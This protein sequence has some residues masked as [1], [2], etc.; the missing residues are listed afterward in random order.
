[1]LEGLVPTERCLACEVCCRFAEAGSLMA[2]VF[3]PAEMS[4]AEGAGLGREAF[5]RTGCGRSEPVILKRGVG[6]WIC[7]AFDQGRNRCRFY[8]NRPLDCRLYPFVLTYDEAGKSVQ[9]AADLACPFVVDNLCTPEFREQAQ[10]LARSIDAAMPADLER[11]AA[12]LAFRRPEFEVLAPLP[13]LSRQ[14]CRSDLGLARLTPQAILD[15]QPFFV[16]EPCE[17]AH[18]SLGPIFVW[19]DLFNLYYRVV[20]DRVLVFGE[21]GGAAFLWLPPAGVGEM[22]PAVEEAVSIL[23]R[24]GRAADTWRI[25]N[26]AADQLA[27]F[28]R[29]GLRAAEKSEEF[30]YHRASLAGLTGRRFHGMRAASNRFVKDHRQ[31]TF[32]PFVDADI[33]EAVG[34]YR[35]WAA[36]RVAVHPDDLYRAQIEAAMLMH[37]RTMR[38]AGQFGL[39]GRTLRADARMV[40]YTFGFR[41]P[42]RETAVIL[43]EVADLGVKG[44]G[45]YIFREFARFWAPLERINTM[46]DSGLPNLRRAKMAYHP[47]QLLPVHTVRPPA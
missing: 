6:Y 31:I 35:R 5:C 46:G 30:V 47:Q 7:P 9:L 8:A 11:D 33:P 4:A 32:M 24:L 45:A 25:D 36:S 22:A 23:R 44:A 26:V 40:G 43:I 41:L 12:F 42:G 27:T 3:S 34:L 37:Y 29:L 1:M 28:T 38:H 14:V 16:A 18:H 20:G 17:L 39:A 15:L 13:R 19:T 10:G 21:E 2:P